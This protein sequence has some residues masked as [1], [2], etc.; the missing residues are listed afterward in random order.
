MVMTLMGDVPVHSQYHRST[1]QS[2]TLTA[3]RTA[4]ERVTWWSVFNMASTVAERLNCLL[5][6]RE[7]DR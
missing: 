2:R 5:G 4:A 7:R 6:C 3:Q 1:K